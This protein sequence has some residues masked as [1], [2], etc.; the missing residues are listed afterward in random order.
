MYKTEREREREKARMC[1]CL[2]MD[3]VMS[4]SDFPPPCSHLAEEPLTLPSPLLLR[5]IHT[6]THTHTNTQAHTNTHAH[7]HTFCN[8]TNY[9]SLLS[10]GAVDDKWP[11]FPAVDK[12]S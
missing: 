12:L 2:H 8:Q 11:H 9:P 3:K 7:T 10:S 5:N 6:S 1:V 4:E